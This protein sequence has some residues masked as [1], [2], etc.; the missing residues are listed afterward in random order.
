MLTMMVYVFEGKRKIGGVA[1]ILDTKHNFIY[2]YIRKTN[3]FGVSG[4]RWKV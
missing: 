3:A 4:I 1:A 2:P